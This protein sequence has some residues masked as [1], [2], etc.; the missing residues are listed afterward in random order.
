M[1]KMTDKKIIEIN[2]TQEMCDEMNE[3]QKEVFGKLTK[4][5]KELLGIKPYKPIKL[6]AL[7]G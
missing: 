3:I 6:K 2:V 4:E 7:F 1:S 5:Q